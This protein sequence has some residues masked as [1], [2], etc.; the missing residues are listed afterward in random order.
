MEKVEGS[1]KV[2]VNADGFETHS[3]EV[4]DDWQRVERRMRALALTDVVGAARSS[5]GMPIRMEFTPEDC[6]QA[7]RRGGFPQPYNTKPLSSAEEARER[8][9]LQKKW[10]GD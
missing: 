7:A 4:K 6:Y 2:T 10:C 1:E 5:E 8:E 3:N 9:I